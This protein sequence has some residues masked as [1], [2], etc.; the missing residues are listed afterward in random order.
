MSGQCTESAKVQA[1]A[2]N[3]EH[4]VIVSQEMD[5]EEVCHTLQP[6]GDVV[7]QVESG[8]EMRKLISSS[9]GAFL[10]MHFQILAHVSPTK[11]I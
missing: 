7:A 6:H 8:F 9:L 10:C 5:V 11:S 2:C 4:A 3:V 1:L